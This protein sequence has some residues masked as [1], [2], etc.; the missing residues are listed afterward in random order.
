MK[1]LSSRL[2][3][4]VEHVIGGQPLWDIGCDHGLVGLSAYVKKGVTEVNFVDPS[5]ESL[6]KAR[7]HLAKLENKLL[8]LEVGRFKYHQQKGESLDWKL[9]HGTVVVAGMGGRVI[10]NILSSIPQENIK[11][12]KF[13]LNP[14]TELKKLETFC[15]KILE[16][17][18]SLESYTTL[19]GKRKRA[20]I[21]LTPHSVGPRL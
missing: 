21:V 10:K 18:H 16:N 20:I 7:L 1:K 9:V 17:T 13:I 8:P 12:I 2:S 4:I 14:E 15:I 6:N 11:N 3:L 5:S 19:E